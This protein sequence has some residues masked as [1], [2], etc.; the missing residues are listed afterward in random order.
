MDVDKHIGKRSCIGMG[1]CGF[2]YTDKINHENMLMKYRAINPDLKVCYD[3][4]NQELTVQEML[5][6]V[7]E[8]NIIKEEKCK[9][10]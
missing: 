7:N 5:N 2:T 6:E 9:F 1:K 8:C 3:E 4:Y 10:C